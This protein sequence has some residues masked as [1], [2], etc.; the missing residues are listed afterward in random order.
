R[1]Y[2]FEKPRL[3]LEAGNRPAADAPA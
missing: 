3:L 2:D 1:D